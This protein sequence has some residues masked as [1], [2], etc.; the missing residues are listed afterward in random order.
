MYPVLLF[1]QVAVL[2]SG[3]FV[4]SYLVAIKSYYFL[5]VVCQSIESLVEVICFILI[6]QKKLV[7][8]LKGILIDLSN[9]YLL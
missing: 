6:K 3:A 7:G 2:D 9:K 5:K 1:C 8:N 4:P